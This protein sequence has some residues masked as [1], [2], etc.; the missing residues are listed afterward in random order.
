MDRQLSA[1]DNDMV[2]AIILCV[3]ILGGI[4]VCIKLNSWITAAKL[5]DREINEAR[6]DWVGGVE[7]EINDEEIPPPKP[8]KKSK[9][10]KQKS[11]KEKADKHSSKKESS[12]QES[13]KS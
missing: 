4:C 6:V 10:K 13:A 11:S 7:D 8:H 3:V 9:K 5:R 2:F 1:T 12:V